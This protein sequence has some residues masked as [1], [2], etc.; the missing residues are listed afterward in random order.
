MKRLLLI[1]IVYVLCACSSIPMQTAVPT[2]DTRGAWQNLPP[3]TDDLNVVEAFARQ[4]P[5][6]KTLVVFDIDDTLL[7]TESTGDKQYSFYGSDRWYVWQTD[8]TEKAKV[9][10]CL[11]DLITINYSVMPMQATQAEAPAI[12]ARIPNDKLVITS[13]GPSN[14]E[15]TL[16]ELTRA[17]FKLPLN[18]TVRSEPIDFAWKE[19]DRSDKV[20]YRDGIMLTSGF[21]KGVMLKEILRLS[22]KTYD[23]VILVD[24]TQ[25]HLDRMRAAIEPDGVK[26]YGT[27]YTKVKDGENL[28][29]VTDEQITSHELAYAA[30]LSLLPQVSPNTATRFKNDCADGAQPQHMLS[31]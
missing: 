5:R 30:I 14:W 23:H 17:G 10:N 13:R 12:V 19:K 9:G 11:I 4:L 18:P 26:F 20:S 27:R 28:T 8:S 25:K 21:N 3:T 24:D 7:T 31:L 29:A 16:R 22:D 6:D 2:A 15:S 1:S